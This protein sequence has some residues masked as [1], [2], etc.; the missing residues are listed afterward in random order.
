MLADLSLELHPL[1][2][3]SV[4]VDEDEDRGLL[5]ALLDGRAG[6][7]VTVP[8]LALILQRQM[9]AD[10]VLWTSLR[11][12][13]LLVQERLIV[14]SVQGIAEDFLDEG[15]RLVLGEEFLPLHQERVAEGDVLGRDRV[16]FRH[17]FFVSLRRD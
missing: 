2:V 14:A 6:D 4:H 7:L 17:L 16:L 8:L 12:V 10:C 1:L 13:L 15:V 11:L 9:K 3:L 5:L